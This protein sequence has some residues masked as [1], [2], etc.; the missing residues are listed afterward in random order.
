[1]DYLKNLKLAPLDL[2]F[3]ERPSWS[4]LSFGKQ[5]FSAGLM[6]RGAFMVVKGLMF[7]LK[8]IQVGLLYKKTYKRCA[9]FETIF[10]FISAV[11]ICILIPDVFIYDI[12]W[13]FY[14]LAM[15]SALAY[16]LSY[17]LRRRTTTL[18]EMKGCAV[19]CSLWWYIVRMI[20]LCFILVSPMIDLLGTP[21]HKKHLTCD[22]ILYRK[23][24]NIY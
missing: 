1:M 17:E 2:F 3:D 14:V 6:V 19:K 23:C 13:M 9:Q 12:N 21:D 22:P 11:K 5:L 15:N 7:V 16:T 24:I 10:L 18:Q 8:S 4:D 20:F